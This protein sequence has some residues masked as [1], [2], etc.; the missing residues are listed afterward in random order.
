MYIRSLTL[1]HN[2]AH[3]MLAFLILT[4]AML[5]D[6]HAFNHEHDKRMQHTSDHMTN[7]VRTLWAGVRSTHQQKLISKSIQKSVVPYLFELDRMELKNHSAISQNTW[8]ASVLQNSCRMH[9]VHKDMLEGICALPPTVVHSMRFKCICHSLPVLYKYCEWNLAF[10]AEVPHTAIA[11]LRYNPVH[12]QLHLC[13]IAKVNALTDECHDTQPL[14]VPCALQ[15]QTFARKIH[16]SWADY[17]T[18]RHKQR[19]KPAS[20]KPTLSLVSTKASKAKHLHAEPNC[21]V[22]TPTQPTLYNLTKVLYPNCTLSIACA[23]TLVWKPD[24]EYTKTQSKVTVTDLMLKAPTEQQKHDY[25]LAMTRTCEQYVL[26]FAQ[27]NAWLN[28]VCHK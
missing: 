3:T 8:R 11:S 28:V 17:Q 22:K 13:N 9:R 5:D 23:N 4:Q 18:A 12:K 7:V 10:W 16:N 26:Q 14:A 27:T 24:A 19:N 20:Q 15:R 6:M 2:P 25:A 1:M 21:C